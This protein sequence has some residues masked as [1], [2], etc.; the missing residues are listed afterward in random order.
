MPK[1]NLSISNESKNNLSVS[2]DQKSSQA[3]PTWDEMDVAWDD[4]D[5]TTWGA[6]GLPIRKESKN[7][8]SITN[9]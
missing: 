2:N 4:T 5:G 9:D 7:N 8:L 3:S 6:P 1:N